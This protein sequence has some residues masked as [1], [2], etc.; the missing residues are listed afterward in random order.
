[1]ARTG[2]KA[3]PEV[4]KRF[5]SLPSQFLDCRDP[6][7]R[8]AWQR[9]NDFHVQGKSREGGVQITH[10]A[11]DEVCMRCGTVKHERFE[12]TATGGLYK[13]GQSYEYPEGYLL[14]GIP[15]GVTPSTIVYQEQYNRAMREA[16]NAASYERE[17]AE[18]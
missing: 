16:A 8:H 6:G 4:A 1:M 7:L 3:T 5:T 2:A 9:L 15:R 14:P 17:H 13:S 12:R 18:R 10:I 11:R